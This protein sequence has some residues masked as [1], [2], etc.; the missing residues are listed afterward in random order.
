MEIEVNVRVENYKEMDDCFKFDEVLDIRSCKKIADGI[1]KVIIRLP[2]CEIKFR[3]I[4]T[5]A[6]IKDRVIRACPDFY[7]IKS[8]VT[9]ANGTTRIIYANN[10]YWESEY[11]KRYA[12][13]NN[14][15]VT[16]I[17]RLEV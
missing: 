1:Y 6:S 2:E 15:K 17:E 9:F 13:L 12:K 10:D 14:C 7:T 16:K 8:R 3:G 5:L 11:A 4:T